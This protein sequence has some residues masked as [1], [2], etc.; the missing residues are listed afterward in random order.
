MNSYHKAY[1]PAYV[2][3]AYIRSAYPFYGVDA[4]CLAYFAGFILE[5]GVLTDSYFF[6]YWI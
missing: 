1:S 4:P 2:D 3:D 6:R 5:D